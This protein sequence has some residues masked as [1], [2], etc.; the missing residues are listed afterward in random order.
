MLSE[1]VGGHVALITIVDADFKGAWHTVV[2]DLFLG[3]M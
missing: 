1:L 2:F 3:R